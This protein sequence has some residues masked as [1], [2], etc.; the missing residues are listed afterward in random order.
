MTRHIPIGIKTSPQAVDWATLDAMWARI[1]TYDVFESVWMN[2]HITN[3]TEERG[4]RSWE[5]VTAMAALA[6]RAPGKWL[7]HGVLSNTFRHPAVLAKQ[8]TL[9]DHVTGREAG[10]RAASSAEPVA[11]HHS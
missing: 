2:D 11:A 5:S 3:A 8:A 9:L 1:G 6:H 10:R 7:G 4:G